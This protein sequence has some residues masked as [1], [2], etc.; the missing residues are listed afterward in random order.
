M[1]M[2]EDWGG[3]L[4]NSLTIE[5]NIEKT[6]KEYGIK[7]SPPSSPPRLQNEPLRPNVL[8]LDE[9]ERGRSDAGA[10]GGEGGSIGNENESNERL[11]YENEQDDKFGQTI[12]QG[13]PRGEQMRAE[14]T[15][16]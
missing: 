1:Y 11:Q 6:W 8:E 5:D 3:V 15:L 2:T 16:A 13:D 14:F 12:R 9:S 4:E 7:T 10:G